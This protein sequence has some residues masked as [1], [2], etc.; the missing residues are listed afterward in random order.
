[1]QTPFHPPLSPSIPHPLLFPSCVLRPAPSPPLIP[2]PSH[3]PMIENLRKY[4]GLIIVLFVL[5]L[6]GFLFMDTS[7]MRASQGGAPYV[8]VAGRTY[9]DKEFSHLGSSAYQ[10]TQSLAQGGDYQLYTFLFTLAGDARSEDDAKMNFFTNRILLRS[11]KGEFG[12][13]P[14]DEEIDTFIRQ[15]RA[16]TGPDGAFSQEQYRNFIEKGIGRLGLTEA[17]IRE[18][19][20]DIIAQRKLAEI[21][22]SGLSSNQGIVAKRIALD[23]QR[24]SADV[25]RI[26]IAPIEEKIDPT[27]EE[28]K[29]YWD[30]VQ[31]A[32]RTPEKRRFSYIIAKP[33]FPAEPAETPAPAPDASE[34]AKAAYEANKAAR[35]AEI[36]EARRKTQLGTDGKVDD[37]L[38]EL[39]S[40]KEL[41]FE[42]L[43][44]QDGWEI[45]ESGLFAAND[46]PG[47]LKVP[48]RSSSAQG[49]AAD[50]LF[51]MN[52][53]SDPFSKI[54]PAIAIGENEWLI[55]K[56]GE[57]EASRVQTYAEARAEARARLIAEKATAALKQAADEAAGKIKA[58]LAEGKT[59][60]EA[61]TAAGIATETVSLPEVTA[62]YQ[63]DTT[64]VPSNLFDAAKYTDPGTLAEPVIESDRAFIVH[65][66]TREV[67]K[68]DSA[69][70][71][72]ATQASQAA[73]S[74]KI[75]A[76]TSW[77]NARSEAADV[78][79]LFRQ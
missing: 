60:A 54:S 48:L 26:D 33:V 75:A 59:F 25:A 20:S 31:D 5:V 30:T 37:F 24:I 28:I 47:D 58:S 38:Y 73:E 74:N 39:E 53:T 56:L 29:T 55:A 62:G 11:T 3:R 72:V 77:L 15:L 18:L 65:V 27:E 78:Q 32:F 17:D 8:K 57:T 13:Y 76:F 22:G 34:E 41:T 6:I 45:K 63:G 52:E 68:S 43:A 67:V 49:T 4:T 19:A 42:E 14:G 64:K 40:K 50:E 61:A 7:T 36:A 46:A 23:S 71:N 12:V 51:R 16:F 44:K 10:L 9:T 69:A 79:P 21:L 66:G 2:P 35:S 1:M 70:T